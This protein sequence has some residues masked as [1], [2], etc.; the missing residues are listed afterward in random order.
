M[1]ND[2]D[3]SEQVARVRAGDEQAWVRLTDRYSSLLWSVARSMRLERA[4]AADVVQTT[5]LRLVERLDDLREPARL[6]SWLVTTARR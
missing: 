6:A 3:T 5:W 4:D 2:E 1:T